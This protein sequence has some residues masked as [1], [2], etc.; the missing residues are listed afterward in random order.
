MT[1][2]QSRNSTNSSVLPGSRSG[3]KDFLWKLPTEILV[4][5]LKQLGPSTPLTTHTS[6]AAKPEVHHDYLAARA[7][8]ANLC[9]VS[10]WI[11][12]HAT[13][14]LYQHVLIM[15]QR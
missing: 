15:E 6:N 7:S 14:R 2:F 3:G 1:S 4:S 5:V 11:R 8:F 10:S 12:P 13:R 9:R